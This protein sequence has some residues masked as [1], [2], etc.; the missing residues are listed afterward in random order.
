M[1][2]RRKG[3]TKYRENPFLK[4]TAELSISGYKK[5]ISPTDPNKFLIVNSDTSEATPAG[6]YFR[7]EVEKN[8][9]VKIY[10]EGAAAL[11]DLKTAGTKV[12]QLVYGQLF[13]KSG[14]DKTEIVLNYELLNEKEQKI[15]SRRTFER[16]ITELIKAGFIAE[17][18]VASYYY[19]N[20]AFLYNGNRLALV[21]EY[22]LKCTNSDGIPIIDH[23]IIEDGAS[24]ESEMENRG[25]QE[26]PGIKE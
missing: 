22:V 20:P 21:N 24:F 26:L 10:A 17:S 11:M 4:H 23:V 8:E 6:F 14:K 5:I 9:F 15:L 3:V 13:G 19:I 18:V 25:Q 16:G 7:K 12:F 1:P 2:R